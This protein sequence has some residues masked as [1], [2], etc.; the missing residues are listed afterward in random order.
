MHCTVL[1]AMVP[2]NSFV[3]IE[4]CCC[5]MQVSSLVTTHTSNLSQIYITKDN[6]KC[7]Y[8][9]KCTLISEHVHFYLYI[10]KRCSTNLFQMQ[11]TSSF[12]L[13]FR[14]TPQATNT[15]ECSEWLAFSCHSVMLSQ[16]AESRNE[17]YFS[18]CSHVHPIWVFNVSIFQKCYIAGGKK[19][20]KQ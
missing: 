17:T 7:L 20:R 10:Q 2:L 13:N 5:N 3:M 1:F 15:S 12:N 14:Y 4:D 18:L 6:S 8:T 16:K 11:L 9:C 19:R